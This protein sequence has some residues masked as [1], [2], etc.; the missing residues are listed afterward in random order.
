MAN[1]KQNK[2]KK[3]RIC[4]AVKLKLAMDVC[5]V[6]SALMSALQ[7]QRG[8]ETNGFVTRMGMYSSRAAR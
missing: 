6:S 2:N 4:V 5:S 1:K 8:I 7:H 3:K